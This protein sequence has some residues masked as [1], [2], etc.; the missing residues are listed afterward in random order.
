MSTLDNSTLLTLNKQ[1]QV[2][3]L[4]GIFPDK[5]ISDD[6]SLGEIAEYMQWAGGLAPMQ[7]AC[8]GKNSGMEDYGQLVFFTGPQW[9]AMSSNQKS[10]YVQIGVRVRAER[11]DFLVSKSDMLNGTANTMIWSSENQNVP[12][13]KDYGVN[14]TGIFDDFD[15]EGMTDAV[16]TW[17]ATRSAT[18]LPATLSRAW[19]G[20]TQA[21]DGV[22][23]PVTWSCATIAHLHLMARYRTQINAFIDQYLGNAYILGSA[24]YYSINEY[25]ASYAWRCH[26][27]SGQVSP[28]ANKGTTGSTARVRAVSSI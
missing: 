24:Y 28:T 10:N 21:S 5:S 25:D 23:D 18:Y 16:C 8:V 12:D 19:K 13:L 2:E 14:S 1:R 4:R 9:D 6:I 17:K 27:G 11:Q 15:A 20:C 3:A 7:M 26:L 22:D